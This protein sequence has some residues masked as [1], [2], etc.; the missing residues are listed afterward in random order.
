MVCFDGAQYNASGNV[1]TQHVPY[2][3]KCFERQP[4]CSTACQVAL[5]DVKA[6]PYGARCLNSDP[7]AAL[8][9]N[10]PVMC[11]C[12]PIVLK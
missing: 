7:T 1:V 5:A 3:C 4:D 2:E 11:G 12:A 6:G 8:D 9:P 10:E